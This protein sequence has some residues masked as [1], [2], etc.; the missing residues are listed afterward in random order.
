M[1]EHVLQGKQFFH[2]SPH[3][4]EEGMTLTPGGGSSPFTEGETSSVYMSKSMGD[5]E[6]WA[7]VIG[8]GRHPAVHIYDVTPHDEPEEHDSGFYGMKELRSKGATVN[9]R[10]RSVDPNEV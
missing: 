3:D 9:R 5:A 7:G 8:A 6:N 10:L 4:L 1:A 2:A